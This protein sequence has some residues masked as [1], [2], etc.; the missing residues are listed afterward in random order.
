MERTDTV[1]L[2]ALGRALG[3]FVALLTL[4]GGLGLA[5]L[6]YQGRALEALVH[7]SLPRAD[8]LSEVREA[9][10]QVEIGVLRFMG[11]YEA[12][13]SRAEA[14]LERIEEGL[15]A[16]A[17]SG[18]PEAQASLSALATLRSH[19]AAID[20]SADSK[21]L[22][23]A[24]ALL[25]A[26]VRDLDQAVESLLEN[27]RA[28]EAAKGQATLAQS[29]HVRLTLVA[30][31]GAG[32]FLAL[33][34][35]VYSLR[36]LKNP[37]REILAFLGAAAEKDLTGRLPEGADDEFGAL[38]RVASRLSE[39]LSGTLRTL[40]RV[41]GDIAARGEALGRRAQE[42]RRGSEEQL[43]RVEAGG[44]RAREIRANL[45]PLGELSARLREGAEQA[46]SSVQQILAMTQQVR[47]EMEGL[48]ERAGGSHR[49]M[50]ELS[51]ATARVAALA[52]QV[53]AAAQGVAAAAVAIDRATETLCSGASEGRRLTEDV[54]GKAAEGRQS[55]TQALNGMERIREAVD[56]AVRSFERLEGELLRVGRVTQV[57]DD[58]AGR[59]N[60]LSLNAAIIAAQA[61]ERGKAFGVVAAEIRSLAE[62]TAA[63][64][65]EI[66]AIVDGVVSGGREAAQAVSEGAVRVADG[67][68]QAG[69]TGQLLGGIHE[70]ADR[71]ATR[72]REIEAAAVGQARE[73][74]RVV[75][76]IQQ[77]GQGVAEI[78]AAVR[79]QE[80]QTEAVHGAL[81][82]IGQVAR[83]V[84][85]A[86]DEQ[87]KGTEHITH[88]VVEV[89]QA[90]E[91]VDDAIG[92]VAH[93][94]E[95][96]GSDLETL[97]TSA[98]HELE[99]VSQLEV[100]GEGLAALA[101]ELHREA[102]A[103]RL[104]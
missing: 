71:A 83:Q 22:D 75:E 39:T 49:A 93:L 1:V 88:T 100:E 58:I 95:G 26:D 70:S 67:A 65:R 38:A 33:G 84:S 8:L 72:L 21:G 9:V 14:S 25:R 37:F 51:L 15:R 91:R 78:V 45:A 10:S 29:R 40:L 3:F 41:A 62:K 98:R 31:L 20:E 54:V 56:A 74:A 55:M 66:R 16:L 46:A 102:A 53:G 44:R 30:A 59:T 76:E 11:Y 94:L 97:G 85:M 69:D 27:L 60:L 5:G 36:R 4:V 6:W 47:A 79:A 92:R 2:R 82:E 35:L 61:G 90:S 64:T 86:S 50:D 17:A 81:G 32:W 96:L 68:R 101:G 77:V 28:L 7:R 73:A 89:S 103:F 104:P 18:V 23:D 63:S 42:A 87:T 48:C 57:I 24:F 13:L 99:R 80:A 34:I 12:D 43:S 19:L 52:G